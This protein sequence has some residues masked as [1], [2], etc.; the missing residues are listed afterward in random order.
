MRKTLSNKI[1]NKLIYPIQFFWNGLTKFQRNWISLATLAVCL[2]GVISGDS[3]INILIGTIGI[4]YVSIYGLGKTKWA[5]ILGVI[6]VSF[7]TVI[8]LQNRIMLD[9]L[10]NIILI[11]IYL[12]SFY[13]WGKDDVKPRNMSFNQRV[14][15]CVGLL[16]TISALFVVSI[17]LNGNYS[18]LDAVNTSC[19]MFAMVLGYYGFT[20]NWICW[21]V[22]NLVSALTFGLVL[23]TPTG[24]LTVFVMKM[25]FFINGLIGWYNFKKIGDKS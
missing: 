18:M 16:F 19:T 7:Y 14:Y 24:S 17:L 20:E 21:S 6:Y 9:A 23:F 10:Q 4:F 11:P 3:L 25:I 22:N 1:F 2:L 15:T 8:C 13:H 12:L 5:F